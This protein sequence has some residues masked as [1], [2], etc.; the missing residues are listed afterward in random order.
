MSV[1]QLSVGQM[2]VDQLPVGQISVDQLS[3]GQ[4]SVDEKACSRRLRKKEGQTDEQTRD[5]E[6]RS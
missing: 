4:M 2:S 6:T 5:D 3:V 1:D